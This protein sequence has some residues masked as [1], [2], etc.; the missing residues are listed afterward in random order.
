MKRY[1]KIIA[2]AVFFLTFSLSA[3]SQ[4]VPSAEETLRVL[5]FYYNGKGEGIVLAD[6]K[7][8][9]DIHRSGGAKFDCKNEIIE[10][11]PLSEDGSPPEVFHKVKTN[12]TVYIWMAY[13]VPMG[14]QE[15]IFLRFNLE[16]ET[17]RTSG[18]LTVKSSIRYRTW[19]NFT[20]REAG[21]WE[22]EIFHEQDAGPQLLTSMKLTVE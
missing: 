11:G 7:F 9:Q 17:K 6:S 22:V 13:M 12:E 8:C 15:K 14:T 2:S 1:L 20:P 3:Y 4:S 18:A 10:F 16:G 5:N 19:A 21:D